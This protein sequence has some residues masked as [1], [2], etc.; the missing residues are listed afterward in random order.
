M[1]KNFEKPEETESCFNGNILWSR[2]NNTI[3]LHLLRPTLSKTEF[4]TSFP[5]LKFIFLFRLSKFYWIYSLK[6]YSGSPIFSEKKS[7]LR[8]W[9]PHPILLKAAVVTEYCRLYKIK[10][11]FYVS[12]W[13]YCFSRIKMKQYLSLSQIDGANVPWEIKKNFIHILL[14][15]CNLFVPNYLIKKYLHKVQH[16]FFS[17]LFHS[18]F[19]YWSP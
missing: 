1:H 10:L 15:L 14:L 18:F 12:R 16:F 3:Q 5:F 6:R 2:W 13:Q 4:L 9:V 8:P 17:F 11:P 7:W 19:D